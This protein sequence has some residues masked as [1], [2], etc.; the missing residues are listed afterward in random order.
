MAAF[1]HGCQRTSPR[2][3]S[4]MPIW[5]HQLLSGSWLSSRIDF[6]P[7]PGIPVSSSRLPTHRAPKTTATRTL[8]VLHLCIRSRI[9]ALHS[10]G[11]LKMALKVDKHAHTLSQHH[12][13]KKHFFHTCTQP[14]ENQGSALQLEVKVPCRR[15][16][17]RRLTTRTSLEVW[18]ASQSGKLKTESEAA[19]RSYNMC[20]VNP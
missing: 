1:N 17:T 10:Q 2:Y 19:N 15:T 8:N 16:W 4:S 9:M 6:A 18:K 5:D 11:S 13:D 20:D 7:T 3:V 12:R 14:C